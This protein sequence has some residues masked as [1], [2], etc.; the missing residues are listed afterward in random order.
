MPCPCPAHPQVALGAGF[1][2][3][4]V[5][6]VKQLLWPYVWEA[7]DSW[8]ERQGGGGSSI[9]PRV[10][11]PPRPQEEGGEQELPGDVGRAVAEAIQVGGLGLA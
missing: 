7:Y 11:A 2:A 6:A 4:G 5:Y 1:F 10:R 8:R 3:A 9:A